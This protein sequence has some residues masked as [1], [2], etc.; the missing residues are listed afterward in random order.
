MQYRVSSVRRSVPWL[1]SSL[2]LLSLAPLKMVQ[3]SP[4]L[5]LFVV[6]PIGLAFVLQQLAIRRLRKLIEEDPSEP[7]RLVTIEGGYAVGAEAPFRAR[8]LPTD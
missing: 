3:I 7:T 4:P 6:L 5:T 1:A 8:L 2:T